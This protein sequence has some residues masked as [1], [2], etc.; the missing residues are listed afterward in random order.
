VQRNETP[1]K[2]GWCDSSGSYDPPHPNRGRVS[3]D[4]ALIEFPIRMMHAG[5]RATLATA[6]IHAERVAQGPHVRRNRVARP[7][8]ETGQR[9]RVSR[10]GVPPHPR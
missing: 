2:K 9:L 8:G 10:R 4:E 3:T 5:F 7:M 1:Q 6:W